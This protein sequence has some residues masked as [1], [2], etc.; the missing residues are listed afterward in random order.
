MNVVKGGM[1]VPYFWFI[2]ACM[3]CI[4]CA[5]FFLTLFSRKTRMLQ[6]APP[7]LD[8]FRFKYF[9]QRLRRPDLPHFN[10]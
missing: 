7:W 8:G 1:W 9:Y 10:I 6:Y 4:S 2:Y 3:V 5:R